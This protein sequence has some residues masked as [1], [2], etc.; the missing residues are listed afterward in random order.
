MRA[1]PIGDLPYRALVF[2]RCNRETPLY[3]VAGVNGGPWKAE[4]ALATSQNV[5]GGSCFYCGT[6]L[7]KAEATIDHVEPIALGGT[8]AIQNLVLSC[9]PCNAR[10]GHQVL[11]FHNPDAGREWLKALLRQIERRLAA[12]NPPSSPPPPSPGEAGVP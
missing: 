11:D 6:S 3:F 1:S 12:I 2:A 8:R 10:K 4:K 5:H 7:A 9:K